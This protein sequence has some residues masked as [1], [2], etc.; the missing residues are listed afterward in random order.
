MYKHIEDV[1]SIHE[2]ESLIFDQ[3]E[4]I[5]FTDK[6]LRLVKFK[7]KLKSLGARYMIKKLILNFFNM[8]N[9]YLDIEIGNEAD[10]KP[11][12]KF[13]GKVK[14][15]MNLTGFQNTQISISHSKNYVATLVIIE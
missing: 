15:K 12:V 6:E 4:D 8:K 2:I 11:F 9:D 3:P 1:K 10:G 5:F 13:S 7:N 14:E